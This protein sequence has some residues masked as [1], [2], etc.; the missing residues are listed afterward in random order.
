[1]A[2]RIVATT[3]N[4]IFGFVLVFGFYIIAHGHL[5]PG[6]GFQGGAVIATALILLIVA[7][8][9]ALV[10]MREHFLER[11]ESFGALAFVALA[12]LGLGTAFF[13]NT[14]VDGGAIFS[15]TVDFGPNDGNLNTG[16]LMPLMNLAVG[17][18]VLAGLGAA[19][20]LIYVWGDPEQEDEA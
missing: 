13:A 15:D 20:Y 1:M 17:L 10:G 9:P 5:T 11:L 4:L 8:E 14:L 16:G 7:R 19:V 3:A 6:G 12:M 18:K 2:S